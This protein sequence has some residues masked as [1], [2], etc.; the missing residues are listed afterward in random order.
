M[1]ELI[2]NMNNQIEQFEQQHNV[3]LFDDERILKLKQSEISAIDAL[4][5][6]DAFNIH[7]MQILSD[8]APLLDEL[9]E[10][11]PERM[12]F[13]QLISTILDCYIEERASSVIIQ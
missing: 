4:N 3:V 10:N 13:E 9:N 6:V 8:L 12:F 1:N 11:N 5:Q 2:I 7:S